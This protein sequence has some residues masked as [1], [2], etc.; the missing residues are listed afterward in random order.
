MHEESK[1]D[2][3]LI[4]WELP[5]SESSKEDLLGMIQLVQATLS[6]GV[7]SDETGAKS[8]GILT[9]A[10]A[11]ALLDSIALKLDNLEKR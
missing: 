8:G 10:E 7:Y 9:Q 6:L 2:L 5:D 11:H 3:E 1:R 4:P